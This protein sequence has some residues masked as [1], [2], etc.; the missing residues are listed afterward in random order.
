MA[1]PTIA[2]GVNPLANPRVTSRHAEAIPVTARGTFLPPLST[3]KE[4]TIVPTGIPQPNTLTRS[5]LSPIE[6]PR[7][8]KIIGSIIPIVAVALE[9]T[10]AISIRSI[11]RRQ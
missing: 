8:L 4:A 1:T 11:E 10:I 7:V 2:V 3:A 9:P 6:K 5:M